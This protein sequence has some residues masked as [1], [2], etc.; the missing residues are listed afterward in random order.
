MYCVISPHCMLLRGFSKILTKVFFALQ[1][2]PFSSS[3]HPL[4]DVG[5]NP[6]WWG[7]ITSIEVAAQCFEVAIMLACSS[8]TV[9]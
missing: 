8:N 5:E 4:S 3:F 1:P 9:A 2:L 7:R 6:L